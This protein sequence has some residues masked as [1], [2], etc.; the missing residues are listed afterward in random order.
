[1]R[2]ILFRSLDEFACR[3][4]PVI[5]APSREDDNYAL[6]IFLQSKAVATFKF[7]AIQ[8]MG[9]VF[10]FSISDP[11]IVDNLIKQFIITMPF[12]PNLTSSGTSVGPSLPFSIC[13][14]ILISKYRTGAKP[15]VEVLAICTSLPLGI[16]QAHH[17]S[18]MDGTPRTPSA[19][20][21]AYT[22]TIS[23]LCRGN[24]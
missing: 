9:W 6:H 7:H 20:P 19:L 2:K 14:Q 21:K 4:G 24:G 17:L 8:I 16:R 15:K 1:M 10:H 11:S 12:S 23:F 18:K 22:N 13:I 5:I 3:F